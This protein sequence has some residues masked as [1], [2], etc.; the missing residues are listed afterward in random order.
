MKAKTCF[1]VAL[2][3]GLLFS[4]INIA[5]SDGLNTKPSVSLK[6]YNSYPVKVTKTGFV[7]HMDLEVQ[8][9]SKS[10][11]ESD[12]NGYVSKFTNDEVSYSLDKKILSETAKTINFRY[13]IKTGFF[14]GSF[15]FVPTV[16][17]YEYK[18]YGWFHSGWN[19]KI[20]ITLN[21][22]MIE[23]DLVNFPVVIN[24]SNLECIY[25]HVQADGD[26]IFFTY[27]N[28]HKLSH[29]LELF[30][31][32]GGLVDI[33]AHVNMSTYL[34]SSSDT[35]IEMYYGNSTCSS[36]E[37][38]TG[39]WDTSKFKAVYHFDDTS[40]HLTDSTSNGYDSTAE[41]VGLT[42][43]QIGWLGYEIDFDTAHITLPSFG[44]STTLYESTASMYIKWDSCNPDTSNHLVFD[45]RAN[46]KIIPYY[47][48]KDFKE[49]AYTDDLGG[50][51]RCVHRNAVPDTTSYHFYTT[52]SKKNDEI[53]AWYDGSTNDIDVLGAIDSSVGN[54]LLGETVADTEPF[55]GKM[56]E[57]R[58]YSK[59]MSDAWVITEA[60][61]IINATDGGFYTLGDC[62]TNSLPSCTPVNIANESV[63]VGLNVIWN[64]FC[65]DDWCN[66]NI[67]IE[68]SDGTSDSFNN[69]TNGNY[70]INLNGLICETNY[71]VWVNITEYCWCAPAGGYGRTAHYWFW[72]ITEDCVTNETGFNASF[73][74]LTGNESS[75]PC[76]ISL[77]FY[78]NFTSENLSVTLHSNYT[79][80]WLPVNHFTIY[81]NGTY[82][83]VVNNWTR[84]NYTYYFNYKYE[85]N[86]TITNTSVYYINTDVLSNCSYIKN[87]DNMDINIIFD[88]TLVFTI[89]LSIIW[90]VFTALHFRYRGEIIIAWVQFGFSMPL[91][92]LYGA[93]GNG[94][95][96]GYVIA[97]IIPLLSI[98]ILVD[99][100][101]NK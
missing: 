50:A 30:S 57:L 81:E 18:E 95:V 59:K 26:D 8:K 6:N 28:C 41:D 69:V 12:F 24:I 85:Y 70:G 56:T 1:L 58:I 92:F 86:D 88:N 100:Y 9:D 66:M 19:G 87:G 22:N 78:A 55:D 49:S 101:L 23:D 31:K 83:F 60:N 37:D 68:C 2:I 35:Q 62:L 7:F 27:D 90:L 43:S 25:D 44:F 14:T 99:A 40:G 34:S 32:G 63:D 20:N 13:I 4:N 54:N 10:F 29:E 67:T 61:S 65:S 53:Q 46:V 91:T 42:Y 33:V 96:M 39:V 16:K 71:T 82:C 72:F 77:C 5:I 89:L 74:V 17:E 38:S 79:G 11:A 52:Q 76:C 48:H 73:I 51:I 36:Q 21:H 3:L 15:D 64:A 84:Y 93:M 94:F 75:C 45:M 47:Y 97:I 98:I 80:A